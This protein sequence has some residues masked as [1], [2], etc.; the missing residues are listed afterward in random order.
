MFDRWTLDHRPVGAAQRV[1]DGDRGVGVA[2]GIDDDAGEAVRLLDPVD[3]LPLAVALAEIDL[4]IER[5]GAGRGA[6]L[7]VG[8]GRRAVDFRFAQA[9]P[10]EVGAVEDEELGGHRLVRDCSTARLAQA[11]RFRN[12]AVHA[13][14]AVRG[15]RR[16]PDLK[17]PPARTIL[18]RHGASPHFSPRSWSARLCPAA[19]AGKLRGAMWG[20]GRAA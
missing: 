4:E 1:E 5:G 9:E 15:A 16:R 10:V 17:R 2:A 19:R 8:Q 14:A 18:P 11:A 13:R 3:E 20:I 6:P 7:D 12:G